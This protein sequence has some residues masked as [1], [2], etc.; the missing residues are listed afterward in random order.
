[1]HANMEIGR[2]KK[3]QVWPWTLSNALDNAPLGFLA[4]D[5]TFATSFIC[6]WTCVK[7]SPVSTTSMKSRA[8]A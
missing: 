3:A 5:Y 6:S 1:M 2:C 8:L 4:I 7:R